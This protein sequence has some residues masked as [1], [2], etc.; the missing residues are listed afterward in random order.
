MLRLANRLLSLSAPSCCKAEVRLLS[1]VE[2]E[3]MTMNI[4]LECMGCL[5]VTKIIQLEC[6]EY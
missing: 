4:Q 3:S 6:V 1:S 5:S 2:S